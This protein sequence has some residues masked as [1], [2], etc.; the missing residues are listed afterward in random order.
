[1][2]EAI[3][4]R[5]EE[6]NLSSGFGALL[7]K[8]IKA[9]KEHRV[10]PPDAAVAIPDELARARQGDCV[11]PGSWAAPSRSASHLVVMVLA[12]QHSARGGEKGGSTVSPDI[13]D[14]LV[15]RSWLLLV[16]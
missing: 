16:N 11:C 12:I 8:R 2:G 10:P 6:I 4:T 1:M 15:M 7:G 9:G 14:S 3:T 13:G 5:W